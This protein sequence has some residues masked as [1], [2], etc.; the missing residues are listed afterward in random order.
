MKVGPC[1]DYLSIPFQKR[2]SPFVT[3]YPLGD[4]KLFFLILKHFLRVCGVHLWMSGPVC[5]GMHMHMWRVRR[6]FD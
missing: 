6:W 3:T 5:M 4:L 2:A 1:A